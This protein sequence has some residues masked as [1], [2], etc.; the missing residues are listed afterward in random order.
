MSDDLVK[1]WR[2]GD[3]FGGVM[4]QAADRIEALT[5]E[6]DTLRDWDDYFRKMLGYKRDGRPSPECLDEWLGKVLKEENND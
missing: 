4:Q 2:K 1:R 3:P 5:K 6:R